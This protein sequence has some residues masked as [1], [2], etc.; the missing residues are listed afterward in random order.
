MKVCY[1]HSEP[2]INFL[3]VSGTH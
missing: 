1:G 3:N 2:F